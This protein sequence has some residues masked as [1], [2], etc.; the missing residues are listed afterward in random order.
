MISK[1]PH[2]KSEALAEY[3]ERLEKIVA[4]GNE[5]NY[6]GI[7][8]FDM[9]AVG[10]PI[11]IVVDDYLPLSEGWDGT[12]HTVLGHIG[13]DKSL[14][15]PLIEKAFAKLHGNYDHNKK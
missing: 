5:L 2:K 6:A 4:N 1:V 3:P 8:A 10:V 9:Y 15:G 12:Y 14:W 7:Y 11:T 13:H